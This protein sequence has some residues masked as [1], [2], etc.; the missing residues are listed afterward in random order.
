MK[1]SFIILLLNVSFLFA[2]KAISGVVKMTS[3]S[4][5][6]GVNIVEKGLKWVSTDLD[7]SY[8]IKVKEGATLIFSYVDTTK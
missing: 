7:G 2:Q 3:G 6:P 5:I 1:K 4:T 8:K